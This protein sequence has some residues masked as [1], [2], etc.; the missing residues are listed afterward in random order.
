MPSRPSQSMQKIRAEGDRSR[1]RARGGGLRNT[2]AEEPPKRMASVGGRADASN[3]KSS[4]NSRS[5]NSGRQAHG[6]ANSTKKPMK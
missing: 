2:P 3:T 4:M 5:S 6:V 1:D